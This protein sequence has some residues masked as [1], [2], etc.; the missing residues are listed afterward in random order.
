MWVILGL[1]TTVLVCNEAEKVLFGRLWLGG[2]GTT[3]EFRG[4]R[5]RRWGE[6]RTRVLKFEGIVVENCGH[7]VICVVALARNEG[8]RGY[9]PFHCRK[10]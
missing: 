10:Y 3:D 8:P 9:V 5:R 1:E 7:G 6:L 4:V 2:D